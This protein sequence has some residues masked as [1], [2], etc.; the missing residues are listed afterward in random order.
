M[1]G[2]NVG[3]SNSGGS[4]RPKLVRSGISFPRENAPI[5]KIGSGPTEQ[6][7]QAGKQNAGGSLQKSQDSALSFLGSKASAVDSICQN[8]ASSSSVV[9]AERPKVLPATM[10]EGLSSLVSYSSSS[11]EASGSEDNSQDNQ[12]GD[13][14]PATLSKSG[15]LGNISSE[16]LVKKMQD[17]ANSKDSPKIKPVVSTTTKEVS[18]LPITSYQSEESKIS[19]EEISFSKM[20]L[21]KGTEKI[22]VPVTSKSGEQ[23][24]VAPTATSVQPEEKRK[25]IKLVKTDP[26]SLLKG[27]LEHSKSSK[28]TSQAMHV[29]QRFDLVKQEMQA[30]KS[31]MINLSTNEKHADNLEKKSELPVATQAG[32]IKIQRFLRRPSSDLQQANVLTKEGVEL[33]KDG[34]LNISV[35]PTGGKEPDK[36]HLQLTSNFVTSKSLQQES[37]ILPSLTK[38]PSTLLESTEKLQGF[39]QSFAVKDT[40]RESPVIEMKPDR[41]PLPQK[42]KPFEEESIPLDPI[43]EQLKLLTEGHPIS[44][45]EIPDLKGESSLNITA[46]ELLDNFDPEPVDIHL[47]EMNSEREL[48]PASIPDTQTHSQTT[49]VVQ[50]KGK[51]FGNTLAE[52]EDSVL[53]VIEG[54]TQDSSLTLPIKEDEMNIEDPGSTV[55]VPSGGLISSQNISTLD[56]KGVDIASMLGEQELDYDIKSNKRTHSTLPEQVEP[57]EKK[58]KVGEM[59]GQGTGQ[60]NIIEQSNIIPKAETEKMEVD[61]SSTPKEFLPTFEKLSEDLA[62]SKKIGM[63]EDSKTSIDD[64]SIASLPYKE[65]DDK[66]D[67]AST[68]S[69]RKRRKKKSYERPRGEGGKF[70]KEKPDP[71]LLDEETRMEGLHDEDSQGSSS[72]REVRRFRCEVIV[73]ESTEVFTADKVVEYVWPLEGCGEHYFIQEQISQY[74]GIMSFKR[75]YPDLRRRPLEM[76]ERDYLKDK[77]LVSEMACDLGLTAVRS[78]DVLDVMLS[79]FPSKFEE[80]QRLL[81]ERKE[82][83]MKERGKV[84]YSMANLDKSKMQE[85]LVKA[86]EDSARWNAAFNREKRE[87]RRYSFDLQTCTLQMPVGRYKKRPPVFTKIGAYP[88]AVLPGQYTDYYREYTAGALKSMPL[89]TVMSAPMTSDSLGSDGAGSDSEDDAPIVPLAGPDVTDAPEIKEEKSEGLPHCKVCTGTKNKNKG[90]KP[91]PLIICSNCRSASHP[92]CIDLTLVMVP[93]IESYAWQCMDCKSCVTCSDPDDEDKMIFCDM[94]DRGYHIFCVGLRRVPNGRWHCKECAVCSSCGSKTPAG[95]ENSKNAEWQHEFKKDKNNKQLKYATTLCVPCDKYWKRRQF[96]YVCLKVYR[97]IPEDG[98]VRCSNCPKYIHREGCS[99]VYENERFCNNCFKI[100]NS[101]ALNHSRI[102][103]AAKK[104]MASGY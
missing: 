61:V 83:E 34:G 74:L 17:I 63:E 103:A 36:F 68:P 71:S 13:V 65:K 40:A 93:K 73:P 11:T 15:N 43:E 48:K 60:S 38:G 64:S 51:M 14:S 21:E 3:G 72:K 26:V 46:K 39:A 5:L 33:K 88:V 23:T 89:N 55:T 81:R 19:K 4:G 35:G 82:D 58:I 86:A 32:Q 20:D 53:S 22:N 101:T 1:D 50:N 12:F 90:G 10:S 97:S 9:S 95:S 54:D 59:I 28:P 66:D 62:A 7:G 87:E 24:T 56:V 31:K 70:R 76:Q 16:T 67:D 42:P 94:C 41:V 99:T 49:V 104:K 57:Q 102:I 91:E 69:S 37:P 96:C 77:G 98:M 78:E 27:A 100:R 47:K 30:E 2:R 25:L 8:I 92:T 80:L 44:D 75:K 29:V 79:D 85:Y 52:K 6:D 84:N 45:M 18:D